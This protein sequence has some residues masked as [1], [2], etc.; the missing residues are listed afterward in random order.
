MAPVKWSAWTEKD[1]A[2]LR[3]WHN[4]GKLPGEMS[5]FLGD[6]RH[7]IADVVR[8]MNTLGLLLV[9]QTAQEAAVA[10]LRREIE[11]GREEIRRGTAPPFKGDDAW[12]Q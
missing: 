2:G 1:D 8:R 7:P 5:M 4:Q 6:G 12:P 10:N 9:S 11:L 3:R